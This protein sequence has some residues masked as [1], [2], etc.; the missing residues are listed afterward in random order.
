MTAIAKTILKKC[1]GAYQVAAW[2][3]LNPSQVYR[4]TYPRS[5]GGT[6]GYIPTKRQAELMRKARENGIP[7][8]PSDFFEEAA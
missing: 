7:L 2:L 5:R 1:G 4:W 3:K 6:G 8:E